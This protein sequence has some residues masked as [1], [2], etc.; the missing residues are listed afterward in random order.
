MNND[1]NKALKKYFKEIKK[2]LNCK[3]YLKQGFIAQFT[4]NLYEYLESHNNKELTIEHIY[5]RFGTPDVIAKSVDDIEDLSA[6][7]KRSKKFL[8]SQI[9]SC[10]IIV[11]FAIIIAFL[12]V[13]IFD[14]FAEDVRYTIV[15]KNF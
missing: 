2:K 11:I 1:L 4:E 8:V 14:L 5:E 6:L 13:T 15:D 10:T 7:R 9:I 3:S 12:V